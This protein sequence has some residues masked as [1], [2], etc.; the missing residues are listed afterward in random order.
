MASESTLTGQVKWFNTKTG[1]G[2]ITVKT[3]GEHQGQDIF[4][5]H[6]DLRVEG[7]QYR[8]LVMGEYVEF[9]L[10]QTDDEHKV[11]ATD[12]QGIMGGSLMC[13][14]RFENSM[15]GED[16]EDQQQERPA[17]RSGGYR[18]AGARGR[19]RRQASGRPRQQASV[20]E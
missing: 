17:R 16:E 7:D 3:E 14:V 13:K 9:G 8:Y 20:Q 15:R 6:S 4:V 2:F 12:V 19:G 11:K 18:G 5:H 10:K 1:F